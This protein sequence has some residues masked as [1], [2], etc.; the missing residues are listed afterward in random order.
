M[1]KFNWVFRAVEQGMYDQTPGE[2]ATQS[3]KNVND[4]ET[5]RTL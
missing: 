4:F 5:E 1:K 2:I 3:D